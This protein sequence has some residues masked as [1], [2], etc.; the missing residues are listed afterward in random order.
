MPLGLNIIDLPYL[1]FRLGPIIVVSFFVLQSLLMWD[2]KGI[3]YLS[4]LLLTCMLA[5]LVNGALQLVL[6]IDYKTV[7][8]SSETSVSPISPGCH[9]ITI[10]ENNSYLSNVPLSLVIY[11][12][13]FF[14]LLIFI[15]NL[16]NPNPTIG[17]LDTT[18][19]SKESINTALN[20]NIPVLVFFPFL[21]IAELAWSN[22]NNCITDDTSK[23]LIYSLTAIIIGGGGGVLWA[24]L[25]TSIG[26]QRLQYITSGN[27]SV[28]SR[29]AKT[30]YRCKPKS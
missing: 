22:M 24:V 4:G 12:F 15:F 29:P 8:S 17:I 21:I 30:T 13:T 5:L 25:I 28:C 6:P 9:T 16:A 1:I 11:S 7:S 23:F 18:K 19:F 10:G 20:D 3:L 27:S 14:Y 2:I 26:I